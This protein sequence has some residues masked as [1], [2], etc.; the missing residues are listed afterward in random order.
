[1]SVVE[2][3]EMRLVQSIAVPNATLVKRLELCRNG[4]HLLAVTNAQTI[5]GFDVNPIW[6]VEAT[7]L[8]TRRNARVRRRVDCNGRGC[9]SME[10]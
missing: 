3:D 8:P 1:M 6:R 9:V 4:K 2:Q 10:R 5:C 7:S